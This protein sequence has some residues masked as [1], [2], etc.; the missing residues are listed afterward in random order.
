[1]KINADSGIPFQCDI[2]APCFQQLSEEEIDLIKSAK[3]QVLFRKGDNL[4]K[5]G[6]FASFVLFLTEGLVKQFIEGDGSRNLNLKLINS[7]EFVGLSSIFSKNTFYYSAVALTD[8]RAIL[9]EKE[10]LSDLIKS[11]GAFGFNLMKKFCHQQEMLFSA[12]HTVVYKQMNGRM[13]EA[14]LYIDG[15]NTEG[16]Q[17]FPLLSRKEVAEFSS[18]STES[19]VK[20]LKSF[21]K[22]GIIRLDDKNI[23]ILDREMLKRISKTG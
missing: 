3:T 4:T 9:I 13:A 16:L 1:M 20:I 8:T 21:E 11:N 23:V 17:V 14:L 12:L 10:A 15:F 7:G 2:Q 6:V 18:V 5:Q 19:A 22:D